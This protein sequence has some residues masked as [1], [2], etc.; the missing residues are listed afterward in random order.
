MIVNDN[1]EAS[2]D[3]S[4]MFQ[5]ERS[6]HVAWKIMMMMMM[7]MITMFK[8]ERGPH[9]ARMMMTIMTKMMMVMMI[10]TRTMMQAGKGVGR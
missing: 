2:E 1:A 3:E 4:T 5:I 9:V 8:I 6:P 10:M 7:M